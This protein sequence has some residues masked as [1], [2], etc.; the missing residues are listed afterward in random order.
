MYKA[1]GGFCVSDAQYSIT[2][3]IYQRGWQ[4]QMTDSNY[5]VDLCFCKTKLQCNALAYGVTSF[6]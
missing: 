3:D 5:I 6:S 1:R 2:I 4:M